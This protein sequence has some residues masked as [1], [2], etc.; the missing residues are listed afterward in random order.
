[1]IHD[2]S[3]EHAAHVQRS[4]CSE[5]KAERAVLDAAVAQEKRAQAYAACGCALVN[6]DHFDA[7]VEAASDTESAVR[8]LEE[9]RGAKEGGVD[10]NS[11]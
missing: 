10:A 1:M 9:V 3:M 8:R 7:W 2:D 5:C 6:C 11:R 4:Q